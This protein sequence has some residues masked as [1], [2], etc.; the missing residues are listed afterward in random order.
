M[1]IVIAFI[2]TF[3]LIKDKPVHR[4]M[5]SRN[6]M[7]QMNEMTPNAECPVN[8]VKKI[9]VDKYTFLIPNMKITPEFGVSI[10]PKS[11]SYSYF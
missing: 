4:Q 11:F 7:D 9:F 10:W 3:S 8:F 1:I 5:I 2:A 6:K